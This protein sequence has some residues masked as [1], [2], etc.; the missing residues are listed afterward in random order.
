MRAADQ[1]LFNSPML[2]AERNLQKQHF[3]A[4]AL[5]AESGPAQ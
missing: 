4:R 2:V 1:R 3:F 5:E